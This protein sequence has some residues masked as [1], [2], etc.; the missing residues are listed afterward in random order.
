[1]TDAYW[2]YYE[3]HIDCDWCGVQTRGRVY[4]GR[5]DV[6]CGSCDRQ[7][8]ELSKKEI[9]FREREIKKRKLI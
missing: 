6:S 4:K 1:M 7:L 5:T 9:V 8:K 3:K 2:R